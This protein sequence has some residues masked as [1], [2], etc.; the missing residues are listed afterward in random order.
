M[1]D[2][3][4]ARRVHEES[5]LHEGRWA[6]AVTREPAQSPKRALGD[7]PPAAPLS[8]ACASCAECRRSC[9]ACTAQAQSQPL[10]QPDMP[11]AASTPPQVCADS[12]KDCVSMSRAPDGCASRFMTRHCRVTCRL[13]NRRGVHDEL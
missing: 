3:G 4:D 6:P 8:A 10:A 12:F 11:T 5:G 9:R 7:R 1:R 13:C 2:M